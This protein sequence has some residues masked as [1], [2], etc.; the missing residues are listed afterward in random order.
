M[1]DSAL[2]IIKSDLP[3]KWQEI[4]SDLITD[5]KELVQILN[6]D[7]SR[8]P[9]SRFAMEQFPLKV[10]RPFV[11]LMEKGNWHDPLLRQIWP[12]ASE[13]IQKTNFV[14]DPLVEDRFN[15]VPGMLHKYHGRV[16]LTAAPH[17]AIHC[18]YCFR[19]HFDYAANSPSRAEWQAVFNYIAGDREIEEVILSGGDP[20]AL[21]DRQL[22]WIIS[23]LVQIPH[24][25]SLRIHTRLAIVI[26]QRINPQLLDTLTASR[27]KVIMVI[28][29]NHA[30]ELGPAAKDALNTIETYNV[31]MLN[32]SVILKDVNDNLP[33]LIALSKV[34]FR[35][36]VLPYY[37]HLPDR[38]ANTSHFDVNETEAKSLIKAM[39]SRLPG[40]LVPQLVR[41]TPGEN[42]K[43]RIG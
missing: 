26:P 27:L 30:R 37:L 5:P 38:V 41:E 12:S 2:A 31:T 36:N 14:A 34:L 23:Q 6:L 17:C 42:A 15:P 16:L 18:R 43:T 29:C 4:L 22:G 1:T 10:P 32:Q 8:N 20:L 7:E 21:A 3:E 39:Q 33:D 11:E 19:R 9:H 13:Q 28:H 35:H 25:T 24:V 40:Y